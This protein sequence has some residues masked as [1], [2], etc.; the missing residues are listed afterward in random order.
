MPLPF[1]VVD[2]FASRPFTGNPAAVVPLDAWLPD[3]TLQNIAA[4]FNL[5]ETA[6]VV[7][8]ADGDWDL[9]WFTPAVEVEM[10]GHATLAAGAVLLGPDDGAGVRLARFH[11]RHAGVLSVAHHG[12]GYRLSLPA[13]HLD[14]APA[15][16][17]VAAAL[18]AE[19]V[20]LLRSPRGYLIAV[21][22]DAAT[23]RGLAP[24]M[25]AVAALPE[26]TVIATAPGDGDVS[27][28]HV[29]SRVFVPA[30]GID[31]DP[32]TGAAHAALTPYW[33]ARSNRWSFAAHQASARGGD[34]GCSLE[35]DRAVLTGRCV[36]TMTGELQV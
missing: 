9:R 2:A 36:V 5:A 20:E 21:F 17:A 25:R 8:R 24:D 1:T 4:E 28:A 14:P 19:L 32:V 7:R 34:L 13:L 12:D 27:G 29:V 26:M 18:G 3:A 33:S 10:C 30:A 23:V 35:D 31:E 6:Y 22:A 15:D 16:P 11:T